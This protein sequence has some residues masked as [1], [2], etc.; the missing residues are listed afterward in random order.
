MPGPSQVRISSAIAIR[1]APVIASVCAVMPTPTCFCKSRVSND[2]VFHTNAA[3]SLQWFVGRTRTDYQPSGGVPD[4]LREPV[5]RNDYV[6]LS[7]GT[8]GGGIPLTEPDGTALRVVH[9]DSAAAAGGNGTIEHPYNEL[10]L[11]NGAGSRTGDIIYAHSQSTF[12]TSIVLQDNQRFLG[13]GNNK[14]FTVATKQE[15]TITIPESSPGAGALTRPTIAGAPGDAVTLAVNNE[16]SNFDINGGSITSRAIAA[17]VGGA[18]N[19][20]IHDLSIK[21][22]LSDGI[23]FTPKTITD[24]SDS[25]KQIVRGNVTVDTV[26]FDN[27]GGDDMNINSAT[28]TDVTSPSVTLQEAIAISNITSTNGKGTG[29]RLQNTHAAGTASIT[30]YANGNATAG[31][32]GGTSADGVLHFND[33]AG[34]VTIN[35]ADIMN[36]TGFAFDFLNVASTSTVNLG[37]NSSYD[38]GTGAA[39]GCARTTSMARSTPATLHSPTA[40]SQASLCWATPRA[41]SILPTR[42][43]SLASKARHLKSMATSAASIN[44]AAPSMSPVRS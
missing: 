30:N 1:I 32:G 21:N 23:E 31:S 8:Q 19:P 33:I 25:T 37:T 28:T 35:N 27:V 44:S 11:A 24:P 20:N 15:G 39:G 41:H 43:R 26:T 12:G 36:N 38:G 3:F 6:T 17:P 4:R 2:E 22:T 14:I 34:P 9:V 13:E 7:K 5:M 10:D 18:G 42:S 40:I 29:L 16:V